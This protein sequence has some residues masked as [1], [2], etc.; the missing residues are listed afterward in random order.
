ML[1]TVDNHMSINIMVISFVFRFGPLQEKASRLLGLVPASLNHETT[2]GDVADLYV[3]DLPSPNSLDVEYK[4]WQRK[5]ETTDEKPDSLQKALKVMI[6][7]Y[8]HS[9]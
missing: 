4:R 8:S 9:G 2:I 7:R 3:N 6:I 1:I 5:W